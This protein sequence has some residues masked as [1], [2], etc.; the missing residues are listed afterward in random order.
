VWR[1]FRQLPLD[2]QAAGL[3]DEETRAALEDAIV[4]AVY[5]RAIGTEAR[6]PVWE[7]FCLFD[8]PL[9][10][11]RSL[12]EIGAERGVHPITA[13]IDLALSADLDCFFGQPL[14][15]MS[16]ED[17]VRL[18][19]HPASVMTF[20][21]AGAH[22]GQISDASIQSHLIAYFVREKGLLALEEAVE[23]MTRRPAEAWG[24]ADRGTLREGAV[25]DINILDPVTFAPAMPEVVHD[26]PTG[27]RRLSQRS[28]GMKATL[29]AGE[30]LVE[31]GEHTGALP[32][33]LLRRRDR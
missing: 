19:R 17:T 3:R 24:F 23:M 18:L 13:L 6:P 22:V 1:E 12:A 27:A 5:G 15:Q 26:L 31:D 11:Y 28:V 8:K 7:M 2:A 16:D 9:P 32:G 20:S 14:T 29:V 4:N 30:V 33:R 25:A 10:P 21:D